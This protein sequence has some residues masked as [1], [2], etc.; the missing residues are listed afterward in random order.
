M[1]NIFI[2]W[3]FTEKFAKPCSRRHLQQLFVLD[4]LQFRMCWAFVLINSF[5]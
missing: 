5:I 3:P 1:L 2:I 4:F